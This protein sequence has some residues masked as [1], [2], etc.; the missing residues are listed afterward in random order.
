MALLHDT[1]YN[2]RATDFNPVAPTYLLDVP[3][4]HLIR[5]L[6]NLSLINYLIATGIVAATGH[7]YYI[8]GCLKV[9]LGGGPLEILVLFVDFTYMETLLEG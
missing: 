8:E 6:D 2:L 9:L 4:R 5:H 7:T 3:L 1:I